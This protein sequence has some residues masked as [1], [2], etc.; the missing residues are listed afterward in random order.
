MTLSFKEYKNRA[1]K[2]PEIKR[3]YDDLAPEFHVAEQLIKARMKAKL[4]QREVAERMHTTQSVIARMESGE[5][6]PSL[7]AI[8]RY[9]K[10]VGQK[11]KIELDPY[12]KGPS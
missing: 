6:L 5:K 12:K 11:I 7:F 1:L 10:A 8:L 9:V 4:T 2:D 3:A